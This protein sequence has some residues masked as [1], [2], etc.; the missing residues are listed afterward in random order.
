MKKLYSILAATGLAL[1]L[2]GCTGGSSSALSTA[3]TDKDKDGVVDISDQCPN[4]ISGSK[5]DGNGCMIYT[6]IMDVDVR[7]VCD[8][9][10]NG[11]ESVIATAKK[12]NAIAIKNDVEFRRLNVNNSDLITSVEEAIKTG[13]KEV[14]PLHFKSKPNKVKKSKTKFSTEYGANRA[15]KFAISALTQEAEGKKNWREAVPGDGYKY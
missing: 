7:K 12:Y 1:A 9:K 3:S 4:T 13:A 5:V 6:S 15:C 2:Q 10:T 14:N 11:I 8:I